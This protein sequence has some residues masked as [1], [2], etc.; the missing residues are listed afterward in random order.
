[1][2]ESLSEKSRRGNQPQMDRMDADEAF[3]MGLFSVREPSF[4]CLNLVRLTKCFCS[5]SSSM[6]ATLPLWFF[7]SW[8]A[9]FQF[10]DSLQ[11]WIIEHRVSDIS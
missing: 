8:M 5:I 3:E 2:P 7:L 1:M 6:S 4:I 10:S 9:N 11:A